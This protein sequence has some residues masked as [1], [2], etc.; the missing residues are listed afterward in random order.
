M[1]YTKAAAELKITQPAVSQHIR[2]LEREY[3]T[4]LFDYTGKHLELTPAGRILLHAAATVSHDNAM[5]KQRLHELQQN[6]KSLVFGATHT[7]GEFEIIDKLA[8]FLHTHDDVNI[9]MKIADTDQLLKA[10]DEGIIDFAI[11]EGF[12]EQEQYETLLFSSEPLL[13]VCGMTYDA[14]VS[15][16]LADLMKERMII[17]EKSAGTRE[18]LER[19]LAEH[20]LT[21]TDFPYRHEVGSP[22]AAKGLAC[23]NCGIAFLYGKSVRRELAQ[24]ILREIKI[25]DFSVTHSF[26]F[27]WRKGSMYST[28]FRQIYTQLKG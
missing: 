20:S 4:K 1:N 25:R 2:Y 5:L 27:L 24:G 9:R 22:Q 13:A 10:V 21:I 26:S 23:R 6:S 15:M 16:T 19:N 14:P 7:I 12:F 3:Q 18:L 17:R 8:D 28:L 11:V